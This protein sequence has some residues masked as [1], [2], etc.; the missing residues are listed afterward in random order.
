MEL[1]N[2]HAQQNLPDEYSWLGGGQSYVVCAFYTPDYL[3]HALELRQS[4]ESFGISHFLKRYERSAGWEAATR[5]KPS[6]IE[7][8]LARLQPRHVLYIDA[9]AA[10]RQPLSFLD[11]ITTDV[12][13]S[14]EFKAR[15]KEQPRLRIVPGTI[16]VRNTPGGRRFAEA[17]R[18]AE[19]N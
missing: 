6:F 19:K 4:L 16:Y 3:A 17:W 8:C 12:A 18:E 15:E 1:V 9:D 7:Y 2:E 11:E 13:L 14:F 10:V 5:I